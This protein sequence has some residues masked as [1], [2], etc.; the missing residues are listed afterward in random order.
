MKRLLVIFLLASSFC[1]C[2]SFTEFAYVRQNIRNRIIKEHPEVK[3]V[4]I[5]N[6]WRRDSKYFAVDII[7]HDGRRLFLTSLRSANL[8]TPFF[9]NRVGDYS[10]ETYIPMGYAGRQISA[11]L[12]EQETGKKIKSVH[13]VI[14]LYDDVYKFTISLKDVDNDEEIRAEKEKLMIQAPSWYRWLWLSDMEFKQILVGDKTYV[15]FK[16]SWYDT[17]FMDTEPE[18]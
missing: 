5:I 2:A 6:N 14:N 15:V 16:T 18:Y 7:F 4:G 1:S 10:F 13:D 17:L 9:I 3:A 11:Q 12:L 8:R